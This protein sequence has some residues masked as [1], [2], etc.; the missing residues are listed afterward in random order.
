MTANVCVTVRNDGAANA[1][2]VSVGVYDR[3]GGMRL[4]TGRTMGALGPT[5]SERVCVSVPSPG[6]TR[7]FYVRVDDDS[8]NAEC[9]EDNNGVTVTVMCGPG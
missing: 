4:G 9:V 5:S 3:M 1:R 7:D 6:A 2:T 8:A